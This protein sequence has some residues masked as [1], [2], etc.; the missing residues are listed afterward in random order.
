KAT[1]KDS[2]SNFRLRRFGQCGVRDL[3][4]HSV[5]LSGTVFFYLRFAVKIKHEA[6]RIRQK[7]RSQILDFRER[8]RVGGQADVGVP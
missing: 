5:L 1:L 4:N 2:L 7:G 8:D 6:E 3:D